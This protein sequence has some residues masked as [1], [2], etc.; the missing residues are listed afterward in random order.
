MLVVLRG[1]SGSGKST[2]AAMLQEALDGPTAIL[3]QDYFRRSVYRE[4]EQESLAHA[5]LLEAAAA[6]CL[7]AGHHVILEGIFNVGRYS[8]MLERTA[9]RSSDSR[10]FAYDLTF[11]ETVRRHAMRPQAAS[12]TVDEMRSWYHGWQPLPFV[13]EERIEAAE[14]AG[15]IVARILG[16]VFGRHVN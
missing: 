7:R 4:R 11:D 5:D 16:T 10:F 12:F 6:H 3:S 14:S 1:N 9:A 8:A 15:Q 13:Q 2:V